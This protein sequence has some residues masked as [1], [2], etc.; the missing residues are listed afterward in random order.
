MIHVRIK[1]VDGEVKELHLEEGC[2][3]EDVLKK[4]GLNP[5][6]YVVVRGDEVLPDDEI[7]R[8]DVELELYS[9]VSGG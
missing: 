6:E 2:R 9:V 7:I 8:E 1:L 4:L 3:V 5:E